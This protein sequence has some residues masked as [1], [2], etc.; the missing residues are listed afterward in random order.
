MIL[1]SIEIYMG[2]TNAEQNIDSLMMICCG[3]IG[4]L[5]T[6]WFRIYANNL[7]DNYKSA[8]NDYL[9]IE[10]GNQR[11]IMRRHAFIGRMIFYFICFSYINCIIFALTPLLSHHDVSHSNATNKN[12][13]RG[14]PIPSACALVYFNFSN[15]I[16]RITYLVEVIAMLLS[17]NTYIG[18]VC[19]SFL[20]FS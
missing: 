1:P 15:I 5:K 12:F 20:V 13:L 4:T 8:L 7:T 2:C 19:L 14:Y 11:S 6:I 9:I 17:D 3:L 10:N 16:Y 18:N